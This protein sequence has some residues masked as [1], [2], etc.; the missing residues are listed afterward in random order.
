MRPSHDEYFMRMAN[1]VA[2]RA[3][4]LRRS[5]GCV[6][7]NSRNH[8]LATGYNGVAAGAPHCNEL[9]IVELPMLS[10]HTYPH[11]CPG[12]RALSGT[13]LAECAAVH[14]EQNAL[15]QCRDV[16]QIAAAYITVAP[17]ESCLK[18]FLNTLCERIVVGSWYA[19][20]EEVVRARWGRGLQLLKVD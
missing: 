15:L 8:V 13:N 14:A 10:E 5:V 11:A 4:C 18:L 20:P 9:V 1:L 2:T 17:C 16:Y 19:D 6:L 3:T 7:V 12:A